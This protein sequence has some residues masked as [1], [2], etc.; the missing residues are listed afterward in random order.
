MCELSLGDLGHVSSLALWLC[1]VS[2]GVLRSFPHQVNYPCGLWS[3]KMA[4]V[5]M[6]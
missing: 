2:L 1:A 5:L 4:R 3:D 6:R